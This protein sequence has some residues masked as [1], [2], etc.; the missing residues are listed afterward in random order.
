[1]SYELI[2]VSQAKDLYDRTQ[3]PL[4]CDADWQEA[5][6]GEKETAE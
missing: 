2:L 3:R 1:M 5:H 6:I 4:E